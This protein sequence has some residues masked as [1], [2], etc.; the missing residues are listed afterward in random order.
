[1]RPRYRMTAAEAYAA[2]V[3]AKE[4]CAGSAHKQGAEACPPDRCL[5]PTRP[6]G[7]PFLR[8]AQRAVVAM[9][10]ATEGA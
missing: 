2:T 3:K 7:C 9:R 1:M 8:L 10:E 5:H 4:L 6:S